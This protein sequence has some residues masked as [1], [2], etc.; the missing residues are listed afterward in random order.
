MNILGFNCY[1]HD[2]AATLVVNDNVVFAVEEERLNRKK[3]YGGIP[4]ESIRACLAFAGLSMSDID[5][6]AFFWKPSI[7]YSKVP[8]FLFRYWYRIPSLLREQRSF[9]VEENLGMLNYLKD[10]RRLPNTLQGLFTGQKMKFRFHLLEHHFCHAASAYYPTP[11]EDAAILT[12]DGAGEWTTS[13][14]AQGRGNKIR[15][16]SSVDTPYSLGAFYQAVSRHLGFKLIEGPGKLMGLASYGDANSEAYKKMRALFRLTDRGGFK[17]DMRYFSYH[18]TRRSGVSKRFTD[19]FGP[20][21]TEG[22]DWSEHELNVAAA[23]QHIVEDVILHQAHWLKKQTG[24]DN[25]CIAGGVGLNSVTNGL[26]AKEGLFKNIFIQP[27]A[28]DSGTSM[29]AALLLGHQVLNRPRSYVMDTAFLGPGY[30][31]AEYENALLQFKLPY[32]KTGAYASFA[33]KK[34]AEGKILGWFQ[35][36]MEFGPRALGN[37]SIIASPLKKEMK[38]ILNARVKFRERFRPFAAIVLEEECGK[39]FDSSYPNPYMLVVY[40]VR[41][42]YVDKVPAITHVDGSV[43]IQTVNQSENPQM[44]KLLE[45]FRQETGYSVLI[46]TSFNIK[47]EPIVCSPYDAV[48]SFV[49]ADMD[50]LIM[51]NFVVAKPGD[52]MSLEGLS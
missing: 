22:R 34:L 35:G 23:A 17:F 29:G 21:K 41:P 48:H 46:N 14:L 39:Y 15:K 30:T 4:A 6:V 40:N 37:R 9:S 52:E 10:M 7:S 2:S 28:G 12:I 33:A 42:E 1:G 20:S 38:D 24:S 36:R 3:H 32:V 51:G 8:V 44:R 45:A 13:L 16:L 47:G 26:I 19:L 27:A 31:E 49:R 18:Y 43:R 25:L 11:Y 50:Y 5:H